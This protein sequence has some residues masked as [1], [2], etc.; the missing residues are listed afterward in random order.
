M[1]KNK[2]VD[3]TE[4]SIRNKVRNMVKDFPPLVLFALLA[5]LYI[6]EI[7]FVPPISKLIIETLIKEGFIDGSLTIGFC[8]AIIICLLAVQGGISRVIVDQDMPYR[9]FKGKAAK[10]S[11]LFERISKI[12]AVLGYISI[13]I[14]VLLNL[15]EY[16]WGWIILDGTESVVIWFVYAHICNFFILLFADKEK[17]IQ[18]QEKFKEEDEENL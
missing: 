9:Y 11:K 6:L 14:L 18:Y 8:C 1:N 5:M 12:L 13:I 2:D 16:G 7:Y 3:I 4:R 15:M 17:L 10:I